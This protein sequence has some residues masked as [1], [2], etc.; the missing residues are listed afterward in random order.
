MFVIR[1]LKTLQDTYYLELRESQKVVFDLRK[2]MVRL[3]LANARAFLGQ[4]RTLGQSKIEEFFNEGEKY[5]DAKFELIIESAIENLKIIA[6]Q[7]DNDGKSAKSLIS[8][9]Q[10]LL[11]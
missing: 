3:I 4:C 2:E 7:N 11:R 6:K 9:F 1:D 10:E 5:P 8:Q